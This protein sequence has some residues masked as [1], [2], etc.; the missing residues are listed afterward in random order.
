GPEPQLVF[1][2][3]T[4]PAGIC[5]TANLP[6]GPYVLRVSTPGNRSFLERAVVLANGRETAVAVPLIPIQVHGLVLRDAKPVSA[7]GIDFFPA[8]DRKRSAPRSPQAQAATNDRGEY[9]TVLWAPGEYLAKVRSAEGIP[10]LQQRV[11]LEGMEET[12]DFALEHEISGVVL[13]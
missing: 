6:A 2:A 7:Y 13:D 10:A 4:D 12:L 5:R 9:E 1:P 8:S 11:R 3:Q